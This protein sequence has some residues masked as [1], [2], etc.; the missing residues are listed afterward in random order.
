MS[1]VERSGVRWSP[2][3]DSNVH[4]LVR[5]QVVFRLAY[6]AI[7]CGPHG[8]IRT[9]IATFGRSHPDPLE[10]VRMV[11]SRGIEPRSPGFQPG[12]MTSLARCSKWSRCRESNPALLLTGQACCRQH[13]TDGGPGSR[14]RTPIFR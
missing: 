11:S 13:F 4:R 8:L 1:F 12:A 10:D 2:R 9:A 14:I 6:E 5:S 3:H 7:A